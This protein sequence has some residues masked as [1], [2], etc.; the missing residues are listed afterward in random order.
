MDAT[1]MMKIQIRDEYILTEYVGG[2]YYIIIV[3]EFWFE[4]DRILYEKM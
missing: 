2:D 3:F 1:E 4:L